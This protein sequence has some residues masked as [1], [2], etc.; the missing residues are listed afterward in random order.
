LHTLGDKIERSLRPAIDVNQSRHNPDTSMCEIGSA[1]DST[2]WQNAAA[3]QKYAVEANIIA[4]SETD[5][6]LPQLT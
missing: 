3:M 1:V 2:K 6:C 5:S 4:L